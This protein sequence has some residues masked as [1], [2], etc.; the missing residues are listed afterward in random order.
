MTKPPHLSDSKIKDQIVQRLKADG[1]Q[2]ATAL[3]SQLGVSPMAIRQ[4][5]QVLLAKDWVTYEEQRQPIGRPVKLWQLTA[6]TQAL[7]PNNHDELA[8]GLMQG[9]ATMF[10]DEGLD[11][12]IGYRTQQQIQ[13][14]QRSMAV[15]ETWRDR[16]HTLATLRSQ[17]G[18][19]AE[20]MEQPDGSLLLIEN[21]CSICAA[22][23]SCA[24]LCDAEMKV[25]SALL[26]AEVTVRRVEHILQGDRR[27]SYHILPPPSA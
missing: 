13:N 10:G 21:H 26:P 11:A 14:Y 3:A 12:L 20:V 24:R 23:R 9:V 19:M 5:L 1:A 4:H 6:V 8:V 18:Y 7:F 22:A 27:C 17:E 15:A 25:F 16:T 2:T